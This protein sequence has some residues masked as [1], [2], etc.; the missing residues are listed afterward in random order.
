EADAIRAGARGKVNPPIR[1]D[2]R[3]AIWARLRAGLVAFVSSDHCSWPLA[4]KNDEDIFASPA[5]APGVAA[6][7]PLF[8]TAAVDQR[9]FAIRE[10]ARRLAEAPARHFGL[11]PRKGAIALGADA[12]FAVAERGRFQFDEQRQ[13]CQRAPWSPYHGRAVG[14][15]VTAT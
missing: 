4:R 3:E 10:A 11:H 15:Q 9:G 5:G 7:L 2:E 12:D 1:A 13:H 6:L 8:F 14:L